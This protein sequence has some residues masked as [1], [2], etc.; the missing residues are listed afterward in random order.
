LRG[1][2]WCIDGS[3][4][5]S[6]IFHFLQVLFFRFPIL[7]RVKSEYRDPSLRSG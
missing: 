7:G 5:R 3:I 1:E 6:N 2:T 4:L